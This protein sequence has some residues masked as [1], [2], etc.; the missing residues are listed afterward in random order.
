MNPHLL[1][2]VRRCD[3]PIRDPAPPKLPVVLQT[4][5][6]GSAAAEFLLFPSGQAGDASA[7]GIYN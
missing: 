2:V 7:L 5:Q 4:S 3:K 1:Q 6:L